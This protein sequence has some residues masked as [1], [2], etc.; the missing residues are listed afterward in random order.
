MTQQQF[1][2]LLSESYNKNIEI[3][4]AKNKDYAD[5]NDAFKNFRASEVLGISVEQGI[6]IRMMDKMV[7]ASN[8]LNR[9]ASVADEKITDTLSDL[10]NYAMILKVYIENK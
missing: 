9:P 3:S 8:L 6:L 1:I 2:E 10:S 4:R 7:R 5:T